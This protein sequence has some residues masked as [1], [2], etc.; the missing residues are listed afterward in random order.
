LHLDRYV[1]LGSAVVGLFVGMTGAVRG[2]LMTP[3]SILVFGVQAPPRS[4]AT[5]PPLW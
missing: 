4:E 5:S 2:A 3:M 1:I